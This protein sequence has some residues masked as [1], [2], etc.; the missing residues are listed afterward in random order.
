MLFQT[1]P[2]FAFFAILY[3]L[4][5]FTKETR[6]RLPLLLAASY[7]FYAWL[8]PLYLLPLIYATAA[9]YLILAQMAKSRRPKTWLALSIAN[10]LGVWPFSSTARSSPAIS[11]CT[12]A[13]GARVRPPGPE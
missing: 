13:G 7:V 4:Y 9:D 11:I 1:L 5:L 12:V 10:S 2:F 8:S 6:L 3:P